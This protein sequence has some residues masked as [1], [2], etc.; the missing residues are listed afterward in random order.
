ILR[1]NATKRNRRPRHA[2]LY[3]QKSSC[4]LLFIS[5]NLEAAMI[6][7]PASRKGNVSMHRILSATIGAILAVPAAGA[8]PEPALTIYRSDGGAL[9]EGGGSPVSDGYAIV[10]E[11]RSIKLTGGRQTVV[12]DGLPSTLDAE[13][14]A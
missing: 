5:L 3:R 7:G 8:E 13:A 4:W 12:I 6:V 11:G 10:H 14:I 2:T 9:F 1:C